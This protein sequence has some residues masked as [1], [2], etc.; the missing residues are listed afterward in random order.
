[1]GWTETERLAFAVGISV[2][3]GVDFASCIAQSNINGFSIALTLANPVCLAALRCAD[4][5]SERVAVPFRFSALSAKGI[6]FPVGRLF[7]PGYSLNI[8]T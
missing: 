3:V 1:L 8:N 2:S 5:V 6:A 4:A 7:K